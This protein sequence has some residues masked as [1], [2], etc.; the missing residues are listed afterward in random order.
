[1]ASARGWQGEGA[2]PPADHETPEETDA[3]MRRRRRREAKRGVGA[4]LLP[5]WQRRPCDA[6]AVPSRLV[7]DVLRSTGTDSPTAD[8]LVQAVHDLGLRD[9]EGV[10]TPEAVAQA[11]LRGAE[12]RKD[13]GR[14]SRRAKTA[15]R[16]DPAASSASGARAAPPVPAHVEGA[17]GTPP[18]HAAAA[19]VPPWSP[20]SEA[21]STTSLHR[22]GESLTARS[23]VGPTAGG[24]VSRVAAAGAGPPHLH[25]NGSIDADPAGEEWGSSSARVRGVAGLPPPLAL[26]GLLP[27]WE[28]DARR[29]ACPVCREPFLGRSTARSLLMALGVATEGRSGRRRHH[30]RC[31]GVLVCGRCSAARARLPALG[32]AAPLARLCCCCALDAKVRGLTVHEGAPAARGGRG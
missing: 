12:R 19:L 29:A 9:E 20:S 13:R 2:T 10:P 24:G 15:A 31:C 30:C 23:A 18:P 28:E 22:D 27:P 17:H 11:A 26:D 7:R 21:T 25:D 6:A 32:S 3:R 16:S 1:M 14:R 4:S 5:D 8:A